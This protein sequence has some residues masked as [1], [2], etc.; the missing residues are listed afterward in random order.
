[1]TDSREGLEIVPSFMSRRSC[2][3]WSR[4]PHYRRYTYSTTGHDDGILYIP[5][6]RAAAPPRPR[7]PHAPSDGIPTEGLLPVAIRA[8]GSTALRKLSYLHQTN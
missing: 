2:Y 7:T 4:T 1:M 6:P 5:A 8:S 3:R